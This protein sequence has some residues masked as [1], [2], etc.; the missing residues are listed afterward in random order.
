ML[1]VETHTRTQPYIHTIDRYGVVSGSGRGD[2]G[3]DGMEAGG[4][5]QMGRKRFIK[6]LK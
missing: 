3:W 2:E 6:Y 5:R 4:R 1:L